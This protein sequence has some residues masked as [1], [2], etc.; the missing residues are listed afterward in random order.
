MGFVWIVPVVLLYHKIMQSDVTSLF[1]SNPFSWLVLKCFLFVILHVLCSATLLFSLPNLIWVGLL[2]Y[3]WCEV[4]GSAVYA[5][6]YSKPINACGRE[7]VRPDQKMYIFFCSL[8]VVLHMALVPVPSSFRK[9][10]MLDHGLGR[11]LVS[12]FHTHVSRDCGSS[13][14]VNSL[15]TITAVACVKTAFG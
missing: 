8:C 12:N 14:P 2:S 3:N 13:L 6:K 5:G 9:L 1:R 15:L 10:L 11:L 4:I 7:T